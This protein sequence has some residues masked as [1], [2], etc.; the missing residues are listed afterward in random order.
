MLCTYNGEAFLATQLESIVNQTYPLH[1][2]IIQDD[3]STDGT[4][5]IAQQ[6]ANRYSTIRITTNKGEHGINSNFFSA[7]SLATGDLIAI[8][9][10]DD[11]W[12]TDKI[13]W[14]VEA[15]TDQTWLVGGLTC[16][17]SDSPSLP[18][19]FDSRIPNLSLLRMLYVGMMPGHTLLFRREM[20]D[21][22]PHCT[23]FMYDLQIQAIA[24]TAERIAYVPKVLVHHRR[25]SAAATY[26][27]PQDRRRNI[28]GGWHALT[29][30]LRIYR[31][32]RPHIK[33]R[34]SEW[35]DFLKALPFETEVKSE[36]LKMSRLQ[37]EDGFV[38]YLKLTSH[39]LKHRHHIFHTTEPNECI[40]I[41]RA[42]VFPVICASYYRYLL[43]KKP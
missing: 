4:L 3:G 39:C 23:Y 25:H 15:M 34:F 35:Q 42:L 27:T 40:A 7:L 21:I 18:T 16:P 28:L 38:A 31:E 14:Q 13:L 41:L 20:L 22:K 10:Q 29:S 37:I 33:R 2:I 5:D 36:A 26:L 24:A 32:L 19:D 30:A 9:D 1:E 17:F 43:K 11:V 6:Y 12:E 8:A